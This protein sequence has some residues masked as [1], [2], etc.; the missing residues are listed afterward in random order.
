MAR[1]GNDHCV[2]V[3]I[4]CYNGGRFLRQTLASV[5]AQTRV[6]DE[7]L[8]VDDG[9]SDDSAQIVRQMD[10]RV[11]L[12]QHDRNRGLAAARNTAMEECT[13]D[14]I[15]FLDVDACA[16]ALFV[17]ALLAEYSGPDV[18]G[19]GGQG[20][21]ANIHSTCDLWRKLN[22]SQTQGPERL[23]RCPWLVG[24]CSSFQRSALLEVGGY[25][26]F[27]R[28]N[29]EDHDVSYR[30]NALGYNLIYTPEARVYHQRT[31]GWRTLH[32]LAHNYVY[33]DF[34]A[35]ARAGRNPTVRHYLYFIFTN[36]GGFL[37][38]D[39]LQRHNPGL[40]VLDVSIFATRLL[41][42]A[43]AVRAA[44]EMQGP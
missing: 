3:A 32:R 28:T 42:L 31:D 43:H 15:V 30:L 44:G 2:T 17:E 36:L 14:V 20:I 16:D 24:M 10:S 7:I 33:W 8:V 6:P 35:E 38:R 21:E 23:E 40:A 18:G 22:V 13:G 5:Q 34:V 4:P 26:T 25:D 37:W 29:G 1:V 39:L 41:A 12:V 27:F 19:V 11:G 9:S